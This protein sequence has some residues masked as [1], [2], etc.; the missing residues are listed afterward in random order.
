MLDRGPGIPEAE[1]QRV[2]EPFYR[3]DPARARHT[4]G[5]GLGLSIAGA[6]ARLNNGDLAL[7]NREG[8]GL[9]ARLLLRA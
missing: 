6:M 4:G 8:G 2:L 5:C 1:L 3:L 9:C 7:F